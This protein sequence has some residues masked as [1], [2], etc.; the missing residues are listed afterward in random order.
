MLVAV[1]VMAGTV[2]E[3]DANGTLVLL[4]VGSV[5]VVGEGVVIVKK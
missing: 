5:G 1:V 3:V 2:V 4:G